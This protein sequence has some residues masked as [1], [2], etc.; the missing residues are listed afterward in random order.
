[1][2]VYQR[3]IGIRTKGYYDFIKIT[4]KVAKLVEDSKIKNGIVFVNSSHNTATVIVQ[5]ND[6]T[7][8]KDL[9]SM[10]EKLLPL[11]A[12]YE[13]D[14]EGNANATAHLKQNILGNSVN[15]PITKGK[16]ILGGW[17]E[18][19]FVELFESRDREIVVTVIGE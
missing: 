11:N 3:T 15:I 1:M 12:K 5:E 2:V 13:H 4:D 19:F 10:F 8:H 7:I 18:I 16:M 14:Y 9:T 6:P 17:Q